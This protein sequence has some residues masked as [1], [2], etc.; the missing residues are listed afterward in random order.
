MGNFIKAFKEAKAAFKR[1][2]ETYNCEMIY[3]HRLDTL[4][5]AYAILPEYVRG[6]RFKEYILSE[7]VLFE[8]VY[9]TKYARK[10]ELKETKL[11]E[12][13][14][15]DTCCNET[16]FEFTDDGSITVAEEIE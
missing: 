11:S 7:V 15:D 13:T 14:A 3:K 10:D 5:D 12:E 6:G 9:S 1:S 2:M 8:T 4:L 16:V